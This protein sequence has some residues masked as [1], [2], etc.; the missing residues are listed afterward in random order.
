MWRSKE[1]SLAD[2]IR[3]TDTE[4]HSGSD[5][6][7]V[8]LP[9]YH[10]LQFC[11]LLF[12]V[13]KGC[14]GEAEQVWQPFLTSLGFHL[15]ICKN[16]DTVHHTQAPQVT[17]AGTTRGRRVRCLNSASLQRSLGMSACQP[18]GGLL[19]VLTSSSL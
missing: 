11:C 10:K 9:P 8:F 18:P 16:R 7:S 19:Q 17:S 1:D 2:C 14:L 15:P 3:R 12:Q 5:G 13:Q 4:L 6:H